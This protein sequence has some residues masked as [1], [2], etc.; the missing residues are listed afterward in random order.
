MGFPRRNYYNPRLCQRSQL[1]HGH[2]RNLHTLHRCLPHRRNNCTRSN[3]FAA[4]HIL[5]NNR[6]Q[7]RNPRLPRKTNRKDPPPLR[8]RHLPRS[9]PSQLPP[10]TSLPRRA[11]NSKDRW[12]PTQPQKTRPTQ[13]RRRLP[14]NLRWLS[15]HARKTQRPSKKLIN[16]HRLNVCQC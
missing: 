3:R 6:K 14:K 7:R 5:S 16:P 13:N 8:L 11:Q 4:L 10:K 1:T 15:S 9:M 12:R 2:L